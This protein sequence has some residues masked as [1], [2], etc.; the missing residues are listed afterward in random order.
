MNGTPRK[1]MVLALHREHPDWPAPKIAAF[2]GV[3]QEYVRA[4]AQCN[5]LTLPRARP[6]PTD[7]IAEIAGVP[8]V[9]K[10]RP[11]PKPKSKPISI[12]AQRKKNV[13]GGIVRKP[14]P[15]Q[16]IPVIDAKGKGI[17][18]MELTARTCRWPISG[19]RQHTL[20]CGRLPDFPSSYCAHHRAISRGGIECEEAT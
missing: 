4:T 11:A 10:P 13:R 5:G 9:A 15:P 17:T 14:T 1:D 3:R 20:F 8:A 19:E 6:V 16:P 2:M 18:L 7:W 12:V